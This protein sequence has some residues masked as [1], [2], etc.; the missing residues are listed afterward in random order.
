MKYKY[1]QFENCLFRVNEKGSIDLCFK[2]K[3]EPYNEDDN[4]ED[5][6]DY[7]DEDYDNGDVDEG[8]EVQDEEEEEE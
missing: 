7:D 4:Y 1:K 2:G 3:W 5:S 6:D 8:E